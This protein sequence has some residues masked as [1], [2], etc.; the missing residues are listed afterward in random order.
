TKGRHIWPGNYSDKVGSG[1]TSWESLEILDQ[2]AATRAQRGATGNVY[3]SMRSFMNGTTGLP[4]RLAS[5]PYAR[6]ALVPAS[7]WLDSIPP[8]MPVV[9]SGRDAGTGAVTLNLQPQG[10]EPTWLWV[11]RSRAGSQW[12]TDIVPGFTRAYA[13]PRTLGPSSLDAV[14]VTAVDRT[15]NESA[16]VIVGVTP[17][18]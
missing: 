10:A 18:R 16:P 12:T 5:G 9:R 7:P 14:V 1:G 13:F 11:I 15:G 3:F 8:S 4:E 6:R 17:A 2:I